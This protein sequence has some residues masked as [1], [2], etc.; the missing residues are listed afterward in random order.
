MDIVYLNFRQGFQYCLPQYSCVQIRSLGLAGWETRRIN[1][2]MDNQARRVAVNGLYP[3]QRLVTSTTE[4]K[5]ATCLYQEPGGG[6]QA[7]SWQICRWH[8][9]GDQLLVQGRAAVQMDP[10]RL[11]G[12]AGRSAMK[13]STDRCKS[14]TDERHWVN[15]RY[16]IHSSCV[17]A[18]TNTLQYLLQVLQTVTGCIL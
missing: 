14:I 9:I 16:Y 11:E 18:A 2:W 8:N 10:E 7:L 4:I 13:S 3:T 6:E 12:W 17:T 15:T 1:S 5:P